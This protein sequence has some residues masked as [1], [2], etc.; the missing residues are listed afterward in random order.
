MSKDYEFHYINS[1]LLLYA[2]NTVNCNRL[3]YTGRMLPT[4]IS[5]YIYSIVLLTELKQCGVYGIAQSSKQLQVD[6]AAGGCELQP[7]RLRVSRVCNYR[8][9]RSQGRGL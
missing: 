6:A 1:L 3:T 2:R 5:S 4:K 9:L 7:S 8:V